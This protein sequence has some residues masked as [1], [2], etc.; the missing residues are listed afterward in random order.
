IGAYA[1]GQGS[2]A[3][4]A[5]YTVTYQGADLTIDQRPVTVTANGQSRLY[6][7]ANPSLTYTT[8]SLGAGAALSGTLATAAT[9]TSDVG[10]Y[11]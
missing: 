11:A 7:E 8:T 4:S 9:A 3:A 6:G 2:L 5:N 10:S 1:I